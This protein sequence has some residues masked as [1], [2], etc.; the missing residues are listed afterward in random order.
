[1]IDNGLFE[2]CENFCNGIPCEYEPYIKITCSNCKKFDANMGCSLG[3]NRFDSQCE[4]MPLDSLV[5]TYSKFKA[6]TIQKTLL[7]ETKTQFKT[8]MMFCFVCPFAP[9]D[10]LDCMYEKCEKCPLP[11]SL[12]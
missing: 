8:R 5:E 1:M 2:P 6:K 9:N 3:I 10:M 4:F 11:K 12:F 7:R